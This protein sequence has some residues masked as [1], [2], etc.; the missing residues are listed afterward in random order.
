V[1]VVF[2]LFDLHS[3]LI[4]PFPS[5]PRPSFCP[6]YFFPMSL[7]VDHSILSLEI[8]MSFIVA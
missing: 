4:L 5:C 3:S 7:Y 1:D 8:S 6:F 2:S